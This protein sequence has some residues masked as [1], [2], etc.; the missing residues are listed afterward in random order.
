MHI[1]TSPP[2]ENNAFLTIR[3]WN[4]W[5]WIDDRDLKTKRNFAYLMYFLSLAEAGAKQSLPLITIPTQ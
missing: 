1:Y 3:Y 2:K 4:K 5:F